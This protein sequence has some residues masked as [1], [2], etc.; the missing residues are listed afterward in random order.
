MERF[1]KHLAEAIEELR[2]ID[3]TIHNQEFT[4]RADW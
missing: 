2:K 1:S 3:V 4:E